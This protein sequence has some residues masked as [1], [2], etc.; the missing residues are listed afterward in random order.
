MKRTRILQV[1]IFF[2][3]A[4]LSACQ[5]DLP[6]VGPD[7]EAAASLF[8]TKS[9]SELDENLLLIQ[10]AMQHV[11]SITPFFDRFTRLYGTPLWQYA[12]PMGEEERDISYLVPVYKEE[13]PN[14]IHTIWFFDIQGDTLRYRTITRENEQ[15]RAYQQNFV[16]DELSY[17]IFGDESA[18]ELKFEDPPQTR[19][20]GKEYY[21]CHYGII[22]WNDIE[23][24]RGLYCKERTVWIS[25]TIDYTDTDPIIGGETGIG[26]GGGTSNDPPPGSIT[27]ASLNKKI[28]DI[29]KR[30]KELACGIDDVD[31]VYEP[32]KCRGN[33]MVI[34]DEKTGKK[35]IYVGGKFFKYEYQD[36]MSIL[37]HEAY[38]CNHDEAWS[39]KTQ[40]LLDSPYNLQI[41]PEHVDYL[42]KYEFDGIT[43]SM[44]FINEYEA[45][46]TILLCP[47]YYKNEINA[48]KAEIG[49]NPSVSE[50]YVLER[51][52][53]LWKQETLYDYSLKH[54]KH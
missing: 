22:E 34:P 24:S 7:E 39:S 43:N 52:Y 48:Y 19:A 21:D 33:A 46:I 31:I 17:N 45:K 27:Q 9:V 40:M 54:Y 10:V 8:M 35:T 16:F 1:I 29:K 30:M 23:V 53:M 15:I 26:G 36:Q 50:K 28:P 25:E 6:A 3:L 38:H 14:I 37:Y 5:D 18:G 49:L 2:V 4:S 13:I 47:E 11:D 12:L 44:D 32:G 42:L 20:W 41:P 51:L